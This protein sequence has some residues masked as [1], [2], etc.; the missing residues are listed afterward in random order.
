MRKQIEQAFKTITI[1]VN[2][3][4]VGYDLLMDNVTYAPVAK[5]YTLLRNR[6]KTTILK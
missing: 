6:P 4:P 3:A 1:T 5:A 2:G